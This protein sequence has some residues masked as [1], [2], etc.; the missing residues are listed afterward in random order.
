MR[1]STQSANLPLVV[2][3]IRS[4]KLEGVLICSRDTIRLAQ[5][6]FRRGELFHVQTD[7]VSQPVTAL[8]TLLGGDSFELDW[9]PIQA[10]VAQPNIN[11]ET[12][13]A[14]HDVLHILTQNGK[15]RSPDTS[16]LDRGFF[17]PLAPGMALGRAE[18]EAEVAVTR[19]EKAVSLSALENKA[20]SELKKAAI[21]SEAGTSTPP[22]YLIEANLLLP[23]GTQQNQ[24]EE[25]LSQISLKEQIDGLVRLH[26][27]GY[28]YYRL[29]QGSGN[30][31]DFGLVL[32]DNGKVT[33]IIHVQ[34]VSGARQTGWEA[35]QT[36]HSLELTP[37]IY[38]VEARVLKAYRAIVS[39]EKPRQTEATQ[40]IFGNVLGAFKQ[41]RR[42]GVVIYHVDRLK[43]YYF[44]LFEGGLQV[45]V[46]GPDA[47]SGRLQ[48]LSTPLAFPATDAS[49]SMTV[50][51]ASRAHGLEA[52]DKPLSS[53]SQPEVII[54]EQVQPPRPVIA[55]VSE[56][57]EQS[58]P[59]AVDWT[60]SLTDLVEPE[61]RS[62]QVRKQ[63]KGN[64]F[65]PYDF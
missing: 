13:Y 3:T 64:N 29:K 39:C 37:E 57:S 44:F 32:L 26:F 8:H 40:E 61:E 35:Y 43:L 25:L 11:E 42:D 50:M 53:Q 28:I 45:G 9:L 47:K 7:E 23:P 30:R 62:R 17:G 22:H 12:S 18:P 54:G 60:T 59:G 65:N 55:T 2:K 33:D 20:E 51:L 38:K 49:A 52:K 31:G 36:L 24:L 48:P 1:R 21:N 14:F 56:A 10:E 5:V 4:W 41:S 16:S 63:L 15:F 34:A 46:F 58:L 19:V 27:T 6:F